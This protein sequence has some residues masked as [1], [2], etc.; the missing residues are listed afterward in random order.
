MAHERHEIFAIITMQNYDDGAMTFIY[1]L[2]PDN[3]RS[4]MG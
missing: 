4:L 2:K 3:V 1:I